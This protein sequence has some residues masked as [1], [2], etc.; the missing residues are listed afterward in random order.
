MGYQSFHLGHTNIVLSTVSFFKFKFQLL[1]V[2]VLDQQSYYYYRWD[3]TAVQGIQEISGIQ[4]WEM[5]PPGNRRPNKERCCAVPF[6]YQERGGLLGKWRSKAALTAG[7]TRCWS[8]SPGNSCV[9]FLSFLSSCHLIWGAFSFS[10][11]VVFFAFAV[12]VMPYYFL[13]LFF[14]CPFGSLFY[15]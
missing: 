5:P 12:S 1:Y 14:F 6:T 11:N 13:Y 2:F 10:C 4:W 7:T 15:L 8:S 3:N 9:S